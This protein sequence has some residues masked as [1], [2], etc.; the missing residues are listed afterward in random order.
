MVMFHKIEIDLGRIK[1]G[2]EN[3]F[4]FPYKDLDYIS[5]I[6]SPCVCTNITNYVKEKVI[7]GE[8]KP[9]S[10]PIHLN[11]TELPVSY[12]IAVE[13]MKDE[14]QYNQNLVFKAI[15]IE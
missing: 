10:I 12:T 13:Y 1:V 4:E 3:K 8:Y 5:R 15:I 11:V 9:N 6:T 14:I 2:S 7:K